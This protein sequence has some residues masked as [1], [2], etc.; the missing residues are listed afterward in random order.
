MKTTI[1]CITAYDLEPGVYPALVNQDDKDP[2]SV[3]IHSEKPGSYDD[4]DKTRFFNKVRNISFHRNNLRKIILNDRSD[5]YFWVDSDTVIPRNALR[6]L[7]SLDK[8]IVG[9]WYPILG[10]PSYAV[11]KLDHVNGGF[12][13]LDQIEP[14]P[15]KVDA[16]GLGCV[17][18]KRKVLETIDFNS[19]LD[20]KMYH[21]N[22]KQHIYTGTSF[23]FCLAAALG[24]F[25][26]W[27]DG[28]V[29]CQH[30]Q[31]KK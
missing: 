24:G 23:E 14:G 13:N 1:V 15:M 7:K 5:F 25:E 16:V 6:V 20:R 21:H 17:L 3:L 8:D 30:L 29:V 2:F 27:V 18:M 12:S 22:S 9:G 19:G 10:T 28:N 31:R 26:T 4:H 11:I